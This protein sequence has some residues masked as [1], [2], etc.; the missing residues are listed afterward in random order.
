MEGF[1][2]VIDLLLKEGTVQNFQQVIHHDMIKVGDWRLDSVQ[3]SVLVDNTMN[4]ECEG[5]C[6]VGNSIK[7]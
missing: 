3:V 2:T 6:T 1:G 5:L 4:L 7:V